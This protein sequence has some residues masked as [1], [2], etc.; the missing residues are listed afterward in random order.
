MFDIKHLRYK[1]IINIKHLDIKKLPHTNV[2]ASS[3][4]IPSKLNRKLFSNSFEI[5]TLLMHA[6]PKEY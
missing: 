1:N 6:L 5:L 3:L 4:F 2:T